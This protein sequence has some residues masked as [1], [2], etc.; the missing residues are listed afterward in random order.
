[1][2]LREKQYSF[3]EFWEYIHLPENVDRRFELDEGLIIE[4][5]ASSKLNTV[6]T[7]RT[8]HFLNAFVIPHDLGIVTSPDA[9]FKGGPRKYRQPDVA[10]VSKAKVTDL[11]GVY[12]TV[13]ADL[14]VEVVSP[15]EDI[16]KKATEYLR[17]GTKIVW[18]VYAED[19]LVYVMTLTEKGG[20][21]SLPFGE[22]D[23]LD[24]GEV[25]PGFTLAVKDIF[26][27]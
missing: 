12:F 20:I 27:S 4:M 23:T 22:G 13:A 14:V 6:V 7:A 9:G 16:L 2:V 1:M 15:D 5:G 8:I 11:K 24:G 26:P 17:A 25:L 10:F 19:R 21:L 3:E 18:A